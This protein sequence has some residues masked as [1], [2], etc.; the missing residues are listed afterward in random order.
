[1]T[2]INSWLQARGHEQAHKLRA[3]SGGTVNLVYLLEDSHIL[4]LN[5]RKSDERRFVDEAAAYELL[6]EKRSELPV[7]RLV[8][9]D[10]S[11]QLLPY[12]ALLITALPGKDAAEV[13]DELTNGNRDLL[14]RELA[15][16]VLSQHELKLERYGSNA[17]EPEHSYSSWRDYLLH[18]TEALIDSH[19]ELGQ[20][21]V[22]LLIN[23]EGTLPE[24]IAVLPVPRAPSLVHADISIWNMKVSCASGTCR[25]SGVYDYEWCFAGDPHYE[26]A[27]MFVHQDHGLDEDAFWAAYWGGQGRQEPPADFLAKQQCYQLL[28]HFELLLAAGRYSQVG[29]QRWQFHEQALRR[30]LGLKL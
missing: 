29:G 4:K 3:V 24:L 7:P 16:F 5:V 26:F 10:L 15:L 14:S 1:L 21:D 2:T 22:D 13:W 20:I 17:Q 25:L 6:A 12:H 28:Y 30:L 11:R 23:L 27:S 19:L 18:K 9:L 8:D